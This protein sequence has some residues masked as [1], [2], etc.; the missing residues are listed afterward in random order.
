MYHLC[1]AKCT[2][3]EELQDSKI[4][5][6]NLANKTQNTG[7]KDHLQQRKETQN[8]FKCHNAIAVSKRDYSCLYMQTCRAWEAAGHDTKS[9]YR[10][11]KSQL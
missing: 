1:V 2:Y 11:P 4:N 6:P 3:S 5:I 10:T 7:L 9:Q 8:E